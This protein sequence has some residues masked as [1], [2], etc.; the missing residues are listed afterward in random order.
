MEF[1][2]KDVRTVL[3]AFDEL[4]K[5]NGNDE[6][7]VDDS[8]LG[9]LRD[10]L[11]K[12]LRE[13]IVGEHN[14][15]NDYNRI[16][17]GLDAFGSADLKDLVDAVKGVYSDI[18]KEENKHIGQLTAVLDKLDAAQKAAV[19]KGEREGADQIAGDKEADKDEQKDES[20]KPGAKGKKPLKEDYASFS[21]SGSF[22]DEEVEVDGVKYKVSGTCTITGDV[23]A[24]I[25]HGA[26]TYVPYGEGS[27][28]YDDGSEHEFDASDIDDVSVEDVEIDDCVYAD[29]TEL[30]EGVETEELDNKIIEELEESLPDDIEPDIDEDDIN[31]DSLD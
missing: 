9:R 26:K 30:P 11:E 22:K 21:C 10:Y 2:D 1:D 16:V 13:S 7:P 3:G 12:E 18:V 27:V 31:W 4:D 24:W 14:T 28:L 20:A 17:K 23:S 6:K 25:S 29:G 5:I 19:E 15:I 8:D